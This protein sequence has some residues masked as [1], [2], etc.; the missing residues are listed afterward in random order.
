MKCFTAEK[1]AEP[2][3]HQCNNK[4]AISKET[5]LSHLVKD[6]LKKDYVNWYQS[7]AQWW[8]DQTLD[9]NAALERAWRSRFE[10]GKMH[11]HQYR[12]ASKLAEGLRISRE[13]GVQPEQ[14]ETFEQLYGWV[15]FVTHRSK[16]LG[17]MTTYDI[18]QR[19]G[20]WLHLSPTVVY[21]HQGSARGAKKLNITGKTAPLSAFPPEIQQLGA[22]HAEN[23]LCIYKEHLG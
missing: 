10:N 21:L 5:S 22:D 18:A 2:S 9:W 11:S 12:V 20:M 15:E 14:F 16:G 17:V 23:F 8:G 13:D 4:P 3:N 6:Y 1:I 19:L 7:E